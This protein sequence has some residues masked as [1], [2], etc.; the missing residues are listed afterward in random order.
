MKKIS[1][2]EQGRLLIYKIRLVTFL[3]QQYWWGALDRLWL[4]AAQFVRVCSTTGYNPS[5]LRRPSPQALTL[6]RGV[7]F[8]ARR[9]SRPE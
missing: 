6:F 5:G 1:W 8:I 9:L 2:H 3:E 7:E 4:R